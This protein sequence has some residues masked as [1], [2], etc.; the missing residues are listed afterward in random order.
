[1]EPRPALPSANSN[2][3]GH[4]TRAL[5]QAHTSAAARPRVGAQCSA[6]RAAHRGCM[7]NRG[8]TPNAPHAGRAVHSARMSQPGVTDVDPL[9]PH[10]RQGNPKVQRCGTVGGHTRCN[11]GCPPRRW[12]RGR[13]GGV[14][15]CAGRGA[16]ST[17]GEDT[18]G[19]GV[20]TRPWWLPLLACGGAYWPLA[21][22]PSAMTSRHPYFAAGI[23]L[24][25]GGNPE[26]NFCP[27]RPPLTARSVPG[28]RSSER[29]Q[30]GRCPPQPAT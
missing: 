17:Q 19:G 26:S 16:R 25:G 30:A 7:G 23:H 9:T 13:E 20:G 12:Q 4:T 15:R 27:W 21:L 14:S 22:E 11:G 6:E 8:Q 3:S 28:M 1:M 2:N 5:Q 29:P 18:W 24:P 10:C